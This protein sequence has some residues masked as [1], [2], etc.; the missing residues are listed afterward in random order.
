MCFIKYI[1]FVSL[2]TN[3][4]EMDTMNTS[5]EKERWW[6]TFT[7]PSVR[8]TFNNWYLSARTARISS[9]EGISSGSSVS[10]SSVPKDCN[11]WAISFTVRANFS[12][13]CKEPVILLMLWKLY[14]HVKTWLSN[15]IYFYLGLMANTYT[16]NSPLLR[17]VGIVLG[18][19]L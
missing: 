13:A 9:I 8:H 3:Q 14:Q 11:I 19:R 18:N 5:S 7:V 1:Y 15:G 2:P 12:I 6:K 17:K 16:M 10:A 4:W